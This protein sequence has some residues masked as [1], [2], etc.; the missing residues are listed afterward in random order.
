MRPKCELLP[1]PIL[2]Y[3]PTYYMFFGGVKR[4]GPE[5]IKLFSCTTQLSMKFFMLINLQLLTMLNSFLL[6]IA[7]H[8]SASPNKNESWH[9]HIY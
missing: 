8:E 3:T 1:N 4:S 7:E 9:F 6:N 5:V 2:M